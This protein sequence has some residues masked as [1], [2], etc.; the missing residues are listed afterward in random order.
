MRSV[1]DAGP[2]EVDQLRRRIG[3][4]LG[5]QAISAEDHDFIRTRLDE[6]EDRIKSMEE[7]DDGTA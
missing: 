1:Q 7:E 4:A 5:A 2:G 3:R 6:I